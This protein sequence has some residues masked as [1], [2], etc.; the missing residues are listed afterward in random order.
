MAAYRLSS[1]AAADL[2]GIYEYTILN[3]GLE[4]ARIYLSGLHERFQALADNPKLGRTATELSPGLR[5]FVHES[6]VVFYMAKDNG[7]RI[8]RVL[9]QSMDAERHI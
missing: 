2:D 6:H 5:R 9:H 8:V 7:V 3:V 4:Q 1:K